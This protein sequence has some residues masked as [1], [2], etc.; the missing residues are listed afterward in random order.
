V[1]VVKGVCG[2]VS[3]IVPDVG[4]QASVAETVRHCIGSLGK[5][6]V[7]LENGR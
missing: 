6:A 4:R 2:V 5:R 1:R 3:D 7:R